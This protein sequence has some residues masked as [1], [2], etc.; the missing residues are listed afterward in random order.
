[1]LYKN[2]ATMI[3]SHP[4]IGLIGIGEEEAIKEHG[5][6]KVVVYKSTF[7]NMFYSPV[8]IQEHKKP[9]LFKLI[10]LKRGDVENCGPDN[11]LVIGVQCI[12]RGTDEMLTGLSIAMTMG[13]TK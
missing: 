1:M 11:Q 10:C 3:F 6:T 9:C 2:I 7:I 12:G 4:P 5:E 8:K 13:A